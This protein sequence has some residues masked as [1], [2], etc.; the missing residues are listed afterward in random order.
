MVENQKDTKSLLEHFSEHEMELDGKDLAEIQKEMMEMS[1]EF[2][3]TAN[4]LRAAAA[5]LE[6]VLKGCEM[7]R[8]AGR[9]ALLGGMLIIGGGIFMS[10]GAA[11][12]ILA[13]GI[14]VALCGTTAQFG[15]DIYEKVENLIEIKKPKKLLSKLLMVIDEIG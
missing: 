1:S 10:L 11:T 2:L 14:G 9:G 4:S 13:T 6:Q 5:K 3:K 15:A 12:P 7:T 8:I